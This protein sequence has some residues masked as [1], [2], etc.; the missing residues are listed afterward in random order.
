[1]ANTAIFLQISLFK[2]FKGKNFSQSKRE[3]VK[4]LFMLL[5]NIKILTLQTVF[6]SHQLL[7]MLFLTPFINF[8]EIY[9]L[10]VENMTE[11]L[12]YFSTLN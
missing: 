1:M 11:K 2:V 8:L 4:F 7:H 12:T 6:L 3:C 5:D 9:E 10:T